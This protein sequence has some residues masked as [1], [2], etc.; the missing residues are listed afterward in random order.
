MRPVTAPASA[1]HRFWALAAPLL[2]QAGAFDGALVASPANPTGAVLSR[3]ALA[4]LAKSEGTFVVPVC[5]A[6]ES[7]IAELD[8]AEIGRAHV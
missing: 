4:D 8:P 6:L 3:K 2:E 1:E 7:Q 5:A